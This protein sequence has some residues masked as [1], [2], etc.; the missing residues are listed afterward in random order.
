MKSARADYKLNVER[1]LLG[2]KLAPDYIDFHLA[3][4]RNYD[5]LKVQDSARFYYNY[6]IEKNPRYEDA[7]LYLINLDLEDKNYNG[8]L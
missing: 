2:K 1:G 7:F 8:I 4:G 6:V 5:L 3:L